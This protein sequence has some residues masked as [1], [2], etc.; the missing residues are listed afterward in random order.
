MS[1]RRREAKYG[2]SGPRVSKRSAPTSSEVGLRLSGS[3]GRTTRRNR[4]RLH[5]CL[6]LSGHLE[7][8]HAVPF[9]S[10]DVY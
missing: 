5:V 3:E 1:V 8:L 2:G 7:E 4:E 9:C 10:I 6:P